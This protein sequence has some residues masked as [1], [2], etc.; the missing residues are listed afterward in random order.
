[1]CKG[2]W[3]TFVVR[4]PHTKQKR[5]KPKKNHKSHET[6]KWQ[7]IKKGEKRKQI[8]GG[9]DHTSKLRNGRITQN[10]LACM[11]Q[12]SPNN[13]TQTQKLKLNR[14]REYY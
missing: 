13:R 11:Q 3:F 1:M 5:A 2:Q 10:P 9:E 14:C 8:N 4:E 6:E 12:H 7:H